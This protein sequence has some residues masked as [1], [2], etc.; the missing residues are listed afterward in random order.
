LRSLIALPQAHP[1]AALT[2][3]KVHPGARGC[4]PAGLLIVVAFGSLRLSE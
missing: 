2:L 4:E 1:F 3:L